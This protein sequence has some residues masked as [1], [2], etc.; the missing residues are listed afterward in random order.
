M[1][2]ASQHWAQQTTGKTDLLTPTF[3]ANH[4][5]ADLL[6]YPPLITKI[7]I[8]VGKPLVKLTPLY[9]H[10]TAPRHTLNHWPRMCHKLGAMCELT[11]KRSASYFGEPVTLQSQGMKRADVLDILLPTAA[12]ALGFL[13]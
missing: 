10:I 9:T 12:N 2:F 13:R 3:S 5:V 6:N 1:D 11:Q 8:L 7:Q 4:G